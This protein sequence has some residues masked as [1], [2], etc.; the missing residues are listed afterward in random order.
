[1]VYIRA[2]GHRA[3]ELD[4]YVIH[5]EVILVEKLIHFIRDESI[6]TVEMRHLDLG[7]NDSLHSWTPT[8]RGDRNGSIGVR[9]RPVT[10]APPPPAPRP[11]FGYA[12]GD[13][14]LLTWNTCL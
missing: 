8:E 9:G 14:C 4:P 10:I 3:Y 13:F 5:T 12:Q 7:H 11:R 1:M 6:R 2:A